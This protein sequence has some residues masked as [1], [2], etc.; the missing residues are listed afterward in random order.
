M[1][2]AGLGS[3]PGFLFYPIQG[4][5]YEKRSPPQKIKRETLANDCIGRELIEN[6]TNLS[7]LLQEIRVI[8]SLWN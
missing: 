8:D 2:S 3:L 4:D 1:G 7:N 6:Y 5:S